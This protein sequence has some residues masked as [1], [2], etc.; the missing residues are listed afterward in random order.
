MIINIYMMMGNY[1]MACG[2][3]YTQPRGKSTD[4][5]YEQKKKKQKLVCMCMKLSECN[6]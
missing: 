6:H 2:F 4:H 5:V 1:F 3:V